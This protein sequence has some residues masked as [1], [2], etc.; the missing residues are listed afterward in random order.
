MPFSSD[1]LTLELTGVFS[2]KR[3]KS[4]KHSSEREHDSLS[5]RMSGE[6]VFKFNGSVQTIKE[7][8]LL[9]L[10][11]S[12]VY[13]QYTAGEDII[14][15]HFM[16]YS[17]TNN[18]KPQILKTDNVDYI[19]NLIIKMYNVWNLKE[20]GYKYECTSLLYHLLYE[21]RKQSA[22]DNINSV[23]PDMLIANAV[24][25]IHRHYKSEIIHIS[26][27][28]KKVALSEVYF[29]KIFKKIYSVSPNKYINNLKLEYAAQLLQ[30]KLYTVSE[31]S[32]LSGFN[33]VKYF[34]KCFKAK[35][36]IT[37]KLYISTELEKLFS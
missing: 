10:P 8:E 16:N 33:D 12:S 4:T 28:A 25:Y 34:S 2:I 35:Y 36:G 1:N 9:Y 32:E 24:N 20:P 13:E 27:L 21:I 11:H 37:P 14:A 18:T 15:I 29:R 5:I 31:A 30:S 23:V 3:S 6:S 26:E 19:R 22:K 7:N 17:S